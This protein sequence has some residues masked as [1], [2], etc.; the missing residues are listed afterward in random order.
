M[1][2]T[3]LLEGSSLVAPGSTLGPAGLT[4]PGVLAGVNSFAPAFS[5]GS[6]P[7]TEANWFGI[8]EAG[9]PGA[10][11]PPGYGLDN[12]T[13]LPVAPNN[14]NT[15]PPGT[16]MPGG[17]PLNTPGGGEGLPLPQYPAP[18]GTP[19]SNLPNVPGSG[20]PGS[21][22][23]TGP[24]APPGT[25][26]SQPG[27][28]NNTSAVSLLDWL[29]RTYDAYNKGNRQ[30]ENADEMFRWANK[31]FGR[32]GDFEEMLMNTYTNPSGWLEGPEGSALNRIVQNQA[33][34]TD[35]RAGNLSNDTNRSVVLQDKMMQ[36]LSNYRTGLSRDS[37]LGRNASAVALDAVGKA[38]QSETNASQWYTPLT[39][40]QG[41]QGGTN[42]GGTITDL[43][44]QVQQIGGVAREAWDWLSGLNF[45]G[46]P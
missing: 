6:L 1:G 41:Q 27:N 31:I 39:Y 26:P 33:L 2:S 22:V 10:Q 24:P 32:S 30:E 3:A 35:S 16:Q 18:P 5:I 17:N 9:F 36:G 19:G 13:A 15:F 29:I 37:A 8:P 42:V 7:L 28:N 12:T 44:N 14:V 38:L 45:G 11:I 46:N 20:V 34:R 23:F 40:G 25:P 43:W 21:P 4:G